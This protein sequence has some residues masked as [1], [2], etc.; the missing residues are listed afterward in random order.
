MI[1]KSQLTVGVSDA[2]ISRT[3]EDVIVTY[4]LGSCIGVCIYD[5]RIRLGGM[6]H[7]QLPDSKL[8]I[9]KAEIRP[10]MFADTG[11]VCLLNEMKTKGAQKGNLTVKLAGGAAMQN[12]PS[13]FEIGKR[14]F[15]AIRKSLWKAGLMITSTDVGGEVARTLHMNI[16]TGKITVKFAGT[17]KEL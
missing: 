17:V 11:L 1:P 6:L 7:F 8:N 3:P 5:A 4:S 9:E 12:G 13:N 16:A 10:Y 15:I 14:N 2:K